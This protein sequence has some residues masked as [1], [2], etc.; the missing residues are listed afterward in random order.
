MIKKEPLY[1]VKIACFCVIAAALNN[2][3]F[4]LLVLS[5]KLPLFVDT[6]FTAAVTFYAGL[7]PGLVTALLTWIIGFTI[8]DD[9]VNPFILCSIA[10]VIIIFLL[11][12]AAVNTQTLNQDRKRAYFISILARLM[13]LYI[14][15]CFVISILGGL[16]DYIFY[17]VMLNI[18][19]VFSA[20]DAFKE[21]LLQG[22]FHVLVMNILSRLPVNI[23]DRFI[24]IFGGFFISQ[25]YFRKRRR[26]FKNSG[27]NP[28]I[29][30]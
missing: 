30:Q 14:T 1:Y 2:I 26:F 27:N 12:P 28:V 15:V 7:I 18:K 9:I 29:F 17:T 4:P 20:E 10:E 22:P 23:V 3:I 19:H 16:I 5:L 13:I 24:V 6:V 21:W 25:C 11:K 8:K